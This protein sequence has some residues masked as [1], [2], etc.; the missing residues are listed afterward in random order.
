MEFRPGMHVLAPAHVGYRNPGLEESQVIGRGEEEG[1]GYPSR[2][3][4]CVVK[5]GL[6]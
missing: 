3:K 5:T 1:C 2:K 4:I 6:F